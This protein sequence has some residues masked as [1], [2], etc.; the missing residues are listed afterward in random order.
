M[1]DKYEKL[2]NLR[3]LLTDGTITEK[4][5]QQEKEKILALPDEVPASSNK[6]FWGMDE[7]TFCLV[8]HLSQFAGY[9]VPLAGLI[10]PIVMWVMEKDN[11]QKVNIHGRHVV[12]WIISSTIYLIISLILSFFFIGIPLL[13]ALCLCYVI[14][15]IIGAMKAGD[16]KVWKY[17]MTINFLVI[18]DY[19]ED[20]A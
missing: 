14:F 17:P 18:P 9:T 1:S 7:K 4:E 10:L 13:I 20:E 2:E 6:Q 5:F 3:K 19:Y 8:L 16:G 11:S 15:P 12:N